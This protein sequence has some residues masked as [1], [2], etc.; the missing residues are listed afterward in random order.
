[1]RKLAKRLIGNDGGAVAPTVGLSLFALIAVGG[2]AFD[3]ARLVSMDTE[4]QGAADQA[5]LAAASQL[6]GQ[7]GA[8]SRAALAART[9]VVNRT[10]MANDSS[11]ISVTFA[12]EPDCDAAGNIRFYQDIGKSQPATSDSNAR[13]VEVQVNPREAIYALTPI[14]GALRSGNVMAIAFAGLGEAICNTPPVMICNPQE[15][16]SN[17]DFDIDSMMGAGLKL[18]SQGGGSGSW[19]PGNYGYLNLPGTSNGAPGVREGLGWGTPPGDCIQQTG[20]S[21]KPGVNTTVTDSLNTRFDI[22]D[23]NQSCPSPGSCPASI[24]SV[25]DV[26]RSANANGNNSCKLHN[27]GWGL[28]TGYY[29]ETLPTSATAPLST[30]Q[31]PAAMGHPRDMCHAA[32]SGAAGACTG[33]I[34]NAA[35]DRDA[36]F[37]VN[38]RRANGTRWTSAEWQANTGLPANAKRY[39]VYKWE[40]DNRGAVID[41]VTVLGPNPPGATGN[42]NVA[43]GRP[44][45]SP[46]EGYGAGTVPD[47]TTPDRRKISV[48]VVNCMAQGVNGNSTNVQVKEWLDVFLVEPSINRNR[49]SAGDIYIEVVGRTANASGGSAVQVVKKSVPYLIE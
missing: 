38:Y 19:A 43:Y 4:L 37:R 25:K 35:W 47:A 23:T 18:V 32:P 29:G 12:D 46:T 36:Y 31:T 28:P 21:T 24:N 41:G 1:M 26:V 40:I 45:C 49:T 3:Y 17:T 42:T 34:G 39:D 33:A 44:V 14:V 11:G 8:C 2:I 22:Y 16:G 10:V 7:T 20:V 15:T 5:A 9:M 13:F 30:S 6:D 48:A 27:N